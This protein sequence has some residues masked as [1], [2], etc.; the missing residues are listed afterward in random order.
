MM[1]K[2]Y[3]RTLTLLA[4]LAL[5]LGALPVTAQ[6]K[7]VITWFVG[8][9]TGTNNEQIETQ[10]QVVADFNASQ[11]AIELQINIAGS[12]QSAPDVL[13]T[14]IASGDAPDIV[15][16][17][18]FSGAYLFAGQWLDL[19]PLVDATGYDLS[20]YADV[21]VAPYRDG[22]ML[23]GIPFAVFPGLL[24]YNVDLFD[25]AG[26][27]YPPTEFG[28]PYIMPDGTEVEW[29]YDTVTEIGK[30][31]TVDSNGNDATS[32][33]FDPSN[34]IQFGF[35]HQWDSIRADFE[36]FGGAPVVNDEGQV[37]IAD[38]WR[39]EAKWLWN[40]VW[41]DHFIPNNTYLNSDLLQPSGFASGNVAMARVM[42]WYT[43]CLGEMTANW[44]LAVV[45]SYNGTHYAPIDMDTFRIHKDTE[46]PE[47]AFTVLQYLQGEAA[48]TLL[49]T[50]GGYA[51]L[52]DLQEAGIQAKADAYPSVENWSVVAPSI[53]YAPLPH[54]ES[55]YPN[56]AKGQ[57]RFADFATL[58][59]GDTGADA[60]LD[61]EL[62]KLQS[63]LQAIVD[64]VQ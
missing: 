39:E 37:V 57:L 62:D 2:K 45:P 18:G 58:I 55:Y 33:D 13:S 43:C 53:D 6:D 38:A 26:L 61:A 11:D 36:T 50:Y 20:Q 10:N 25:E 16:P 46:H 49:T 9:G 30:I 4:L 42:L 21:L 1:S 64:E 29:S 34:I 32:P 14:L 3:F 17:V 31:L 7:V 52:P 40:G 24:Y 54:H 41:G 5:V 44:D 15:G 48:L 23:T 8:L 60:D 56:Y 12:N 63:D 28:A 19:Q 35:L 22:D 59:Y 51:A 47:E 27:N